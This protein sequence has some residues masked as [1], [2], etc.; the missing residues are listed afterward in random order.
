V[1]CVFETGNPGGR[2]LGMIKMYPV[3]I[4]AYSEIDDPVFQVEAFDEVCSTLKIDSVV[5]ALS[6]PDISAA[7]LRALIYI[8]K[9]FDNEAF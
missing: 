9:G 5:D 1:N 4:E 6:W 7:I 8:E 3:K 2:N